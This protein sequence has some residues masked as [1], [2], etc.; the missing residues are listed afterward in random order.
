MFL[1]AAAYAGALHEIDVGVD[2]VR[3]GLTVVV[4][5]RTGGPPPIVVALHYAGHGAPHFA[6]E[7]VEMLVRPGL[8]ELGAL[9][10]A[11]DCPGRSWDDPA[12]EK[13]VSAL[14]DYAARTWG[15]DPERVVL[16]GYS[17]GANAAWRLA[18]QPSRF[19][20]VVPIA[21]DPADNVVGIPVYAIAGSGDQLFPPAA[22]VAAVEA[23]R[24]QV[25]AEGVVV[26]GLTHY[27]VAAYVPALAAAV[28]WIRQ[29][30]VTRA[31][32]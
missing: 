18:S 19:T 12:S 8:E 27:D 16:T 28:P 22:M 3:T 10:L 7:Y 24:R 31:G 14:I 29:R 30:L 5:D 26:D 25:P 6:T 11:P 23:V 20:V 1:T 32:R 15:G 2:G 17:M 4:P 9:I 21:G 13:V